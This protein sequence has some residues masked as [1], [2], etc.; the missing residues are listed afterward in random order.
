MEDSPSPYAPPKTDIQLP[1]RDRRR[2][3]SAWQAGIGTFFGGPLAGVYFL[4]ANLAA[5][6]ELGQA[7]TA[8]VVGLL[9]TVAMQLG[10]PLL[11]EWVPSAVLPIVYAGIVYG[12]TK[13]LKLTR[14][15]IDSSDD[16]ARHSNVHVAAVAVAGLMLFVLAFGTLVMA[17]PHHFLR[18]G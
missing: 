5:K 12:T 3:F 1:P 14:A 7:S 2:A 18:R 10:L 15:Q 6:G 17:F 16:L 11:P 8:T 4:R 9:A 13:M